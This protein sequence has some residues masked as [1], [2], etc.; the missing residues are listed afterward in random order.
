MSEL[1]IRDQIVATRRGRVARQGHELGHPVPAERLCPL[2]PFGRDPFLICE[3]KRKSPSRGA[4]ATELNPVEQARRYRE[5]GVQSVSILTEEDHFA[6]SL[7]DLMAVKTAFPDMAVLRKDFLLD[8]SDVRVSY[9]AGADAVLLIASLF[10]P[11]EFARLYRL[12]TQLGMRA[13]VEIH[14]DADVEVVRSV[15]PD[16]VGINSR[17]LRTFHV[18]RL[19]PPKLQVTLDWEPQ[20]VFESGVWYEEDVIFA[21]S[22]G[23][24]GVLVGESVTRN[25]RLIPHLVEGFQAPVPDASFW[26]VVAS[27]LRAERPLVK[28]CGIRR[29]QDGRLAADLGAD[30][31]GFVFADSPRRADASVVRA[32]SDVDVLKVAVVTANRAA[33]DLPREVVDLLA[34]RRLHAVQFH[35]DEEPGACFSAHYPYYKALR[36]RNTAA[37][38]S[39]A[40]YR[41]PRVLVDAY[42]PEARGGTGAVVP[43][44]ILD[45]VRAHHPLWLAGGLSPS[46]IRRA[47]ERFRPELV[48]VSSGVE[49]RP[50]EKDREKLTAYFREISNADNG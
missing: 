8:E 35:G 43:E 47:I 42:S 9:R 6:G 1:N 33:S 38:E 4:I 10:Q 2:V 36:L 13:L 3:I 27:K 34:D 32:L 45:E 39:V 25:P 44:D 41:S 5:A 26:N 15:E 37:V 14:D 22:T 20:T 7:T 30:V 28:I 17:D 46:T 18:D 50:G 21:R 11:E 23:F 24:S 49:S 48:D 16:L 31:L 40:S 12:A 29:E 19:H